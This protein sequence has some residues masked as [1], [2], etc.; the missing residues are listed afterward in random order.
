MPYYWDGIVTLMNSKA[1]NPLV[2][3][4]PVL[5]LFI[6]YERSVYLGHIGS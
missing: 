2:R 3:F 6:I 4:I 5:G 1:L